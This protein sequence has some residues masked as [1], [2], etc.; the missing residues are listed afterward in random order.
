M[1]IH[2]SHPDDHFTII[3]NET[4]RDRRLSYNARGVLMELL[5]HVDGWE[6]NAD[7]LSQLARKHRGERPGEGRRALRAAFTELEQL[8]Y[9]VRRKERRERGRFV[10]TFDLFDTPGHR[11][12][13]SGTSVR[14]DDPWSAD[15]RGTAGGMSVCGTSADGTSVTGTSTRST[16]LRSTKEEEASEEHSA[17]LVDTRAADAGASARDRID[18]QL[19]RFY[20]AV[21]RLD[22][23]TLRNWLLM[24]EQKRKRIYRTCRNETLDQYKKENPRVLKMEVASLRADRLAYKYALRHY[25]PTP[26]E[27]TEWPAWVVRP[28]TE[29]LRD[30]DAA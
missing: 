9:L 15:H 19:Q 12:T 17:S 24:F 29:H 1:R 20:D 14:D 18:E 13:G 2:R 23:T 3:P 6:T 28:L 27:K 4:L 5:S 21:E 10:T 22:E 30:A 16:N 25:K 8:G 11:D 7:A 26:P